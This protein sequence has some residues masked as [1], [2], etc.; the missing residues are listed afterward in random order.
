MSV[1][2]IVVPNRQTFCSSFDTSL[3]VL[4]VDKVEHDETSDD[5]DDD[6]D[7]VDVED[8]D[9]VGESLKGDVMAIE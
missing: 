7:D 9:V 8:N 4:G 6:D 2:G 1:I 5:D 3:A